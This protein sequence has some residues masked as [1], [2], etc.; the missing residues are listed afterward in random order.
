MH[1]VYL[2]HRSCP[3][4]YHQW[5]TSKAQWEKSMEEAT[6]YA[7][8]KADEREAE[9]TKAHIKSPLSRHSEAEAAEVAQSGSVC[10]GCGQESGGSDFLWVPG[11]ICRG[12]GKV[13][14]AKADLACLECGRY[15]DNAEGRATQRRQAAAKEACERVEAARQQLLEAERAARE[16][17][18]T[19]EMAQVEGHS[20]SKEK[21]QHQPTFATGRK[22]GR[23][24]STFAEL[25]NFKNT[26]GKVFFCP[27]QVC[28]RHL[29]SI[30]RKHAWLG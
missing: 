1:A 6:A 28:A 17:Q 15:W 30:E 8:A 19:A 3:G 29:P 22:P 4:D 12:C 25:T 16:H 14:A 18:G 9:M 13:E 26:D 20:P 5:L 23:I 27:I 10:P 2:T 11:Y 24:H 21:A 7:A